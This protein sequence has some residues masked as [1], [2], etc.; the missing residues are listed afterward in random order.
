[1][2]IIAGDPALNAA[3]STDEITALGQTHP[4]IRVLTVK[5]ASHNVQR[6]FPDVVVEAALRGE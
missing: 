2:T 4:H 3:V 6:E 5:G 1:M